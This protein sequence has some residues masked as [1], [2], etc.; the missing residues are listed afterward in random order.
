LSTFVEESKDR[1]DFLWKDSFMEAYKKRDGADMNKMVKCLIKKLREKVSNNQP[2]TGCE[3]GVWK[4]QTSKVLLSAFPHLI[5]WMVDS[6]EHKR[7]QVGA[8][9]QE[10]MD[11]GMS[12]A[13]ADTEFASH[14]RSVI[15]LDSVK[16]A[17]KFP[18][19][20]FDF[21]FIDANHKYKFVKADIEAWW[22]KVKKGGIAIGHDY[23]GGKERR[24][25]WGV[26]RAIDEF[27]SNN[28]LQVKTLPSLL[29]Y[30]DK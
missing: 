13:F 29:W 18:N 16:A 4:G 3:I 15:S 14:R 22:P 1:V 27:A 19:E 11:N 10:D 5:Y 24:G 20:F 2:F 8:N 9:T 23:N 26:K 12:I 21:V 6:W 7:N 17:K 25:I 28:D 30:I